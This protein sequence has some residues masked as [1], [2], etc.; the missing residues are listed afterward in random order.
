MNGPILTQ[1]ELASVRR[2]YRAASL[3]PARAYHDPEILAWERDHVVRRDWV[4][5]AREE[6]VPEPASFRLVD[7]DGENVIIVRGRD[8][9]VRAFYN[10]CRH[11]GTAVEERECGKAVRFQ[12]VYHSWIYD[13]EGHLVRAKHTEDLEDFSFEAYSL[14]PIH[15][16]TWQ[17][18]IFL[19]LSEGDVE[20]LEAQ[21]IPLVRTVPTVLARW[22]DRVTAILD[23]SLGAVPWSGDRAG[24]RARFSP[25]APSSLPGRTARAGA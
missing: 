23:S 5:V 14:V 3:L 16:A 8:G 7:L 15:A 21:L 25:P 6:D 13:L 19:N 17:G 2:E 11:R 18:F 20:P 1:A 4:L 22:N 9:V 10:V 12:C 24:G